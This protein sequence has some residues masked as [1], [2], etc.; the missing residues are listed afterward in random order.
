MHMAL[1]HAPAH[2][3]AHPVVTHVTCTAVPLQELLE[4]E[5]GEEGG[6]KLPAL[7]SLPC[8]ALHPFLVAVR[9]HAHAA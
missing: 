1:F 7:P 9:D 2:S 4:H 6:S 5:M 3:E 8:K